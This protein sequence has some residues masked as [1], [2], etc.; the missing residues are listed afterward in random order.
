M[1]IEGLDGLELAYDDILRGEDGYVVM[2]VD[3]LG[4][5]RPSVDFPRVDPVHGYDL[6]LTLDID[7]QSIA[8]EEL[9]KGVERT[10]AVG[11]LVVMLDPRTGEVLAMVNTRSLDPS[12]DR[13]GSP[14][15]NRIITDMFEP[16]SVFKVVTASAALEREAVTLDQTFDAEGGRY[17]VHLPGGR[18]RLITDAHP[19]GIVTFREA[20]EVSSNIVFAKV[21]DLIGVEAMYTT[22]RKF[23]FGTKTGIE[24][25]G[26]VSG[27][28]KKPTEWS[29]TTLNTMAYGY[30]VGVTP[31][32]I[33]C[34]YGAIANG[35]VLMRP[36][37]VRRVLHGTEGEVEES[38][39]SG[40]PS[41]GLPG[42]G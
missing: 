23:G 9:R 18:T 25:P 20:I 34:A 7:Y 26:E 36:F 33:A 19:Y 3:G 22:A 30:E 13:A 29:G 39:S 11:G 42:D 37:L 10:K 2:Q 41:G 15:K 31:M 40:G 4:H 12:D 35:G 28:L 1:T 5:L 8:E 32:Q 27:Q 24:L 17:L 38:S 16:G 6:I 21:S 14:P